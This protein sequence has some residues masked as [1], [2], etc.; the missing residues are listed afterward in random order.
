M[1]MQL[2]TFNKI[3]VAHIVYSVNDRHNVTSHVKEVD[4]FHD[5]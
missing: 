4:N 1:K 3:N 5:P 2:L